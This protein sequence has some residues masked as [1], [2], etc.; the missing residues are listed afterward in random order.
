MDR[1]IPKQTLLRERRKLLLKIAIVTAV[2]VVIII[3][4]VN[5]FA[6]G[7][8]ADALQFSTVERGLYCN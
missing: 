6:Q 7:I 3:L 2:V 4:L 8:R 1:E 5:L